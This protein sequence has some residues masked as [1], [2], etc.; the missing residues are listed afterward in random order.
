MVVADEVSGGA[1]QDDAAG[2]QD[3][4]AVRD[5]QGVAHVLLHR[6]RRRPRARG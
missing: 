3:V 4:G 6:Q 1:L 5:L 2:L